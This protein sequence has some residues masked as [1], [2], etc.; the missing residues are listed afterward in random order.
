MSF[1][2]FGD[3]RIISLPF[4]QRT[5]TGWIIGD[6]H[7][8]D[9][10]VFDFLFKD[11]ILDH[12]GVLAL[13]FQTDLLGRLRHRRARR[14]RARYSSRS[15]TAPV[16]ASTPGGVSVGRSSTYSPYRSTI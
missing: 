6:K 12:V 15:G 16:T 1:E 8:T 3:F 5:N 10:S 7:R 14:P 2:S 9:Q 11:L 4:G 13:R